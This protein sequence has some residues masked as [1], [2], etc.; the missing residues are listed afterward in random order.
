[1][2]SKRTSYGGNQGGDGR[3]GTRSRTAAGAIGFEIGD[4]Y[5]K[6]DCPLVNEFEGDELHVSQFFGHLM[7]HDN[8]DPKAAVAISAVVGADGSERQGDGLQ[9][10]NTFG[11]FG[12]G[13]DVFDL[14]DSKVH[15]SPA[16]P[17]NVV[18]DTVVDRSGDRVLKG[19]DEKLCVL[20][21]LV[22]ECVDT[23]T[24]ID[25]AKTVICTEDTWVAV[26]ESY[27]GA[28]SQGFRVCVVRPS[29]PFPRSGPL[30]LPQ[31]LAHLAS[32]W[33]EWIAGTSGTGLEHFRFRLLEGILGGK[34]LLWKVQFQNVFQGEDIGFVLVHSCYQH[35]TSFE[36]GQEFSALF[37]GLLAVFQ[38]LPVVGVGL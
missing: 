4:L 10:S 9:E 20:L 14:L 32:V 31:D 28:F 18:V 6:S 36:V 27:I 17:F 1:M 13:K 33:T 15:I 38:G 19:E 34:G 3:K 5:G 22:R 23:D 12:D 24:F 7:R 21:P 35:W 26:P 16:L 30:F 11:Y 37:C 29:F 25:Q 2:R 8:F